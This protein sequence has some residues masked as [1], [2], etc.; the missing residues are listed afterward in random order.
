MSR[1]SQGAAVVR[2][3]G[4][5]AG[6]DAA[7]CR[8]PRRAGRRLGAGAMATRRR[9][10]C[11]AAR[12]RCPTL[13][14]GG[15]LPGDR[16]RHRL[17]GEQ[18]PVQPAVPRQARRP[19]QAW[20]LTLAQ[21]TNKQRSF[22]NG[23]FGMPPEAAWRSCA[24][25]REHPAPLRTEQQGRDQRPQPLPGPDS[26]IRG[27]HEGRKGRHRRHH[28]PDLGPGLRPGPARQQ[29]L[30]RQPAPGKCTN[31]TDVRQGE[32]QDKI[33]SRATYGCHYT[34]ARLLYT[35]TVREG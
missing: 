24:G 18:R 33:N 31:S 14:P 28:R 10:S 23:F 20:T 8:A 3:G 2:A 15:S 7:A 19:D 29:R 21:P 30:A 12:R 17:S 13:V 1:S 11:W 35:A 26:R 32:P 25:S 4:R 34:T 27:L 5:A 22:F 16:Q 6:G 9:P